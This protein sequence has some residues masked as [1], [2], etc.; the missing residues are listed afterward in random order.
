M[1]SV[2]EP[3][4]EPEGY[5]AEDGV[6]TEPA[7]G[8]TP[9]ERYRSILDARRDVSKWRSGLPGGSKF[10][11]AAYD[12][13]APGHT[14]P[15]TGRF[16]RSADEKDQGGAMKMQQELYGLGWKKAYADDA[17]NMVRSAAD[18][19]AEHR[20]GR[21]TKGNYGK[22]QIEKKNAFARMHEKLKANPD[23]YAK[24]KYKRSAG[25]KKSK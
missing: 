1:E 22:Y 5:Y 11:P 25:K 2:D 12:R 6:V 17:Y 24:G 21:P 18:A 4:Y 23:K 9:R 7:Y 13:Y 10:P 16:D 14:N 15:G 3:A 19:V 20:V 8:T